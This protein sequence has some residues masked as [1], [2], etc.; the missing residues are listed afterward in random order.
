[1]HTFHGL[2]ACIIRVFMGQIG[3]FALIDSY[4]IGRWSKVHIGDASGSAIA[5]VRAATPL[6]YSGGEAARFREA[7]LRR[8]VCAR[9]SSFVGTCRWELVVP[10]QKARR[11]L[12]ASSWQGALQGPRRSPRRGQSEQRGC[13]V[14]VA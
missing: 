12:T 3:G 11:R 5:N 9:V 7:H 13:S 4:E 8:S 14:N 1:M 10:F 2:G 6:R